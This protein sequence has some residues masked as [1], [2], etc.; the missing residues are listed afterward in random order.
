MEIC[1]TLLEALYVRE[2]VGEVC[3]SMGNETGEPLFRRIDRVRG[4][5]PRDMARF[6]DEAMRDFRENRS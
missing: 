4:C 3:I 2:N 1:P 5:H 6:M